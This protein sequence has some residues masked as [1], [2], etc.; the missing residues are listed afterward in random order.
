MTVEEKEAKSF[1]NSASFGKRQ[2]YI[3]VAEMLK[4]GFD[5]YMTLV[6]DQQ[7]DCILR[8]GCVSPQYIDVQ[9]KARSQSAKHPCLFANLQ[10]QKPRDN[11]V[12]IFFSEKAGCY[13]VVPSTDLLKIA[14]KVNKVD[15][16]VRYSI[17]FGTLLKDNS[18]KRYTQFEK[19]KDNFDL[20]KGN[21]AQKS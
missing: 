4:R 8:I 5:V 17:K 11:Y 19:Y 18:V 14:Q 16:E 2:E 15:G 21:H 20:L 12:F 13:W 7:I 1:R 3:A 6:D 10:I 9:I